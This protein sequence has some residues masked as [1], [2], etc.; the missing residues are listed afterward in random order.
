VSSDNLR[1][2]EEGITRDLRDRQTYAGYLRLDRLLGRSLGLR[3]LGLLFPLRFLLLVSWF[4]H[5]G[6]P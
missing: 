6:A 5:H 3:R 1:D 4:A 2:V